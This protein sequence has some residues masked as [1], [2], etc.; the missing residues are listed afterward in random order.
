MYL[1]LNY[2]LFFS[3]TRTRTANQ[4]IKKKKR[5]EILGGVTDIKGYITFLGG[6]LQIIYLAK[7]HKIG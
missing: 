5:G 4:Y 7:M 3:Q 6:T 1:K 2:K